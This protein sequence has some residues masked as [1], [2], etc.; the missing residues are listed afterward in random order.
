ME[1]HEE[2]VDKGQRP[3]TS[4]TQADKP[5]G[6]SPEHNG[7]RGE[8][9]TDLEADHTQ[10]KGVMMGKRSVRKS[11]HPVPFFLEAYRLGF[12]LSDLPLIFVH[13]LFQ[14]GLFT[15]WEMKR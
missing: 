3:H 2:S 9:D 7:H 13:Q 1:E 12:Y 14:T 11:I 4:Q 5:E 15:L 6:V 10:G 8:D